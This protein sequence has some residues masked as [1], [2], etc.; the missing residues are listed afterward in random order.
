MRFPKNWIWEQCF[1]F[2]RLTCIQI[3]NPRVSQKYKLKIKLFVPETWPRLAPSKLE[4]S[5]DVAN[6]YHLCKSTWFPNFDLNN[7][8]GLPLQVLHLTTQLFQLLA[9][10]WHAWYPCSGWSNLPPN[11]ILENK[12]ET[13]SHTLCNTLYYRKTSKSKSQDHQ[14]AQNR[15]VTW[16][17]TD[18]R[19]DIRTDDRTIATR[20][21]VT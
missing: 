20:S 5:N 11:F 10:L 14:L 7:D 13:C 15:V 19:M 6:L 8:E 1:D 4:T 18:R 12:V 9:I 16:T 21:S 2:I 3:P 17:I